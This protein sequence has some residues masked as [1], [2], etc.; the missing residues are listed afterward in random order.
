[1]AQGDAKDRQLYHCKQVGCGLSWSE[2]NEYF[3]SRDG[4]LFV[5]FENC[6]DRMKCQNPEHQFMY[7]AKIGDDGRWTWKCSVCDF[8]HT[9]K[10]NEWAIGPRR[11]AGGIQ[12]AR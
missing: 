11:F 6:K 12:G 4:L 9:S 1:M 8:Q 3:V 2:K 7:V 5:S 10:L